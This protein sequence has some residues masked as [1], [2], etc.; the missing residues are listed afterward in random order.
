MELEELKEAAKTQHP[1]IRFEVTVRDALIA[2]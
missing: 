1:E 2:L